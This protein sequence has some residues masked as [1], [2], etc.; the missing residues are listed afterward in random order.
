MKKACENP[1]N[2]NQIIIGGN[3]EHS[4]IGEKSEHAWNDDQFGIEEGESAAADET[5][6][7][8]AHVDNAADEAV[9]FVVYG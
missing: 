4:D 2:Q 7:N 9:F 8:E 6:E 5:A 1:G 3:Y